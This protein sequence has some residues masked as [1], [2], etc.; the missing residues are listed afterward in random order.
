MPNFP[1]TEAEVVA[2]ADLMVAGYTAHP[3]DF[4]SIDP[5]TDLVALQA[6]IAVYQVD[7]QSQAD[8]RAQ[9]QIA[10]VTKS[11]KLD[12]LTERIKSIAFDM[13]C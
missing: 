8:A 2:L 5:L 9:A 12:A 11:E 4:P 7:K 1:T 13:Y 6:A 10:T 3:A